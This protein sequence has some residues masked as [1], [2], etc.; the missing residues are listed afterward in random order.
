MTAINDRV[1]RLGRRALEVGLYLPLGIY[2]RV[3]DAVAG[4][5]AAE[6]RRLVDSFVGRGQDVAAPVQRRLRRRSGR[7]AEELR[8]Q[9][10]RLDAAHRAG[11]RRVGVAGENA[12]TV[13]PGIATPDAEDLPIPGYDEL[14]AEDII[15]ALDGLTNTELAHVE[16]YEATHRRRTGVLDA[17]AA[18]RTPLPIATYDALTASEI[19]SRLPSLTPRELKTVRDYEAATK[20]RKTVLA[21]ID[22]RLRA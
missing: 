11:V 21:A 14:T 10:A 19:R 20:Q 8:E 18:R 13:A 2:D 15:P 7:V 3:S 9:A 17:I 6:L 16:R 1:Q 22:A 5:D 4:L 12:A